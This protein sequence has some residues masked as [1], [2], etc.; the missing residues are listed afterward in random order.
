MPIG[1]AALLRA[2]IP[3]G[4]KDAETGRIPLPEKLIVAKWGESKDLSGQPVIV[5]ST[6]AAVLAANQD[7]I[8]R[9]EVAL[10]FE[11]NSLKPEREPVPVAAYGT[12]A[13]EEGVGITWT[14]C[15]DSW[16]PEGTDSYTGR[17]Y[18]DLSPTVYRD[19]AGRVVGIHSIA[20]TRAGQIADL[21]AYS[22]LSADLRTL[23]ATD[24]LAPMDDTK[25][26]D[27]RT[28]LCKKLGLA[29]DCSEEE[30]IA[31][32]EKA[33]TSP[34][35]MK[36]EEEKAPEAAAEKS[37]A[38]L[39]TEARLES[40][41]KKQLIAEAKLAGK[42]IPLSADAIDKLDKAALSAVLEGLKPGQVPTGPKTPDKTEGT[43]GPVA[44]SAEEAEVCKTLGI[45]HDDYRKSNPAA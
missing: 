9:A 36:A 44:L 6:T 11:H 20:L 40:L 17:H 25:Q 14:P 13:V 19:D 28:L 41:E 29:A 22:A 24:P 35:P 32:A 33:E 10:D 4:K 27:Y 31:A 42:I 16:T 18:R 30:L 5:D 21:R 1:T 8:G 15:A 39:S 34:S 37:P 38:A 2:P 7:K 43:P 12:L 26:P 45:S 3:L 23:T